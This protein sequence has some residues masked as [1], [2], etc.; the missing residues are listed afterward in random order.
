MGSLQELQEQCV[1]HALLCLHMDVG[2][3]LCFSWSFELYPILLTGHCFMSLGCLSLVVTWHCQV[4]GYG[5]ALPP[6]NI[7]SHCFN[8]N[9]NATNPLVTGVHGIMGAY[10]QVRSPIGTIV[11]IMITIK[12][13]IMTIGSNIVRDTW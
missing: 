2:H 3:S 13:I 8:L 12:L 5:A 4:Y 10:Q 11:I 7:V 1:S 6:N 9:G